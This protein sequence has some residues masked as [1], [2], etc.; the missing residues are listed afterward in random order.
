MHQKK[1]FTKIFNRETRSKSESSSDKA[2]A[3]TLSSKLA[4]V[5]CN[6]WTRDT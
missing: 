3:K 6:F 5:G 4:E 2:E 1:Y